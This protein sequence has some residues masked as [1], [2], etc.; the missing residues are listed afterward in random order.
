MPA[1]PD[2]YEIIQVHHAAEPEVIQAAYRRLSLKYHP[3]VYHGADAQRRMALLNEAYAVL[4]DPQRRA[5]Y[6]R[7]RAGG[8]P[9]PVTHTSPSLQVSPSE[10]N[11]GTVRLSRART[12]SLH[13][14]N[15]G[16]GRLSGLVVAHVPW[17]Q[18]TPAEFDGNDLDVILRFKP[19]LPGEYR[20]ASAVEVYSNGGRATIA[21]R[22]NVMAEGEREAAAPP[23]PFAAREA[24][25][26]KRPPAQVARAPWDH[27]R[28][29]FM[30]WVVLGTVV[31][32]VVWFQIA[33]ILAG[34]PI[35]LGIWLTW[36]RLVVRPR[37][38]ES[39]PSAS[40]S[41]N[42]TRSLARCLVCS[43]TFEPTRARKC[44]RCGGA[45]CLSCGSCACRGPER[46]A[47]PPR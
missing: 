45:I 23:T 16:Q 37:L 1:Q 34:L 40:G 38:M 13:L 15:A 2:Y 43:A 44:A 47:R 32:S 20:S 31:S 35:G 6:D 21:V 18:V 33:P 46:R 5:A 14:S 9:A 12:L 29:P 22:G 28:L 36:E 4:S 24:P 10:F 3:D 42:R 26:A 30:A 11:L 25:V 8:R 17:L 19:S 41:R 27:V 7:G 39:D